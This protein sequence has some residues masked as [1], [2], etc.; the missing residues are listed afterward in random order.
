MEQ[1]KVGLALV[2]ALLV[3]G[4]IEDAYSGERK[5]ARAGVGAGVGAGLGAAVGAIAGGRKGALIGAG[6][7]A[8]AGGGVGAYMDAEERRLREQL[9][10]TDV[11][12]TRD[13]DR[14]ILNMPGNVTFASGSAQVNP[15]F[16]DVLDSIA[17]VL[18]EYEKTYID[19]VGH[20]DSRGSD[21]FNQTLSEQRAEAVAA[22]L[23]EDGVNPVRIN[24]YG[25]GEQYP[26]ASNET[27]DGRQ[28]NRR[29]ELAL[30]P[31][32]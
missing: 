18:D 10:G 17:S 22:V 16:M 15:E 27:D 5:A 12:V 4:C 3:S 32:T 29:V 1:K 30:T 8:I 13:G 9:R 23:R 24:A 7:G 26:I 28:A 14:I 21:T 25:V 11:S 2:A 31:V 20:T 6:I 19:V